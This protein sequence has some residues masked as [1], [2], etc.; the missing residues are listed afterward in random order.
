[1]DP[2]PL[3][4]GIAVPLLMIDTRPS[5]SLPVPASVTQIRPVASASTPIGANNPVAS[6]IVL[7]AWLGLR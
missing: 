3:M 7:G 6:V 4:A 2:K 5:L 1:M